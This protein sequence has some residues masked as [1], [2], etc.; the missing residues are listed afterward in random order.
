MRWS[1]I[2][3]LIFFSIVIMAVISCKKA[4]EP[5]I[6]KTETNFLVVDGQIN[7]NANAETKITLSRTKKLSDS[8]TFEPELNAIVSLEQEQGA[9]YNLQ[10]QGN[11]VY[12]TILLN[13]PLNKKYRIKIITS[14]SIAYQSEFVIAKAAPPIDSIT[15]KQEDNVTISVHSRDAINATKYYRWDYVETWSYNSVLPTIWGVKN[16]NAFLKDSTTQTDSCWR[17]LP[18]TKIV[19]YSTVALGKDVVSNYPVAI[20][21]KDDEK[22]SSRYSMLLYQYAITPEAYQYFKLI[23]KNSQQLGTLFDTQPS[24]I[25]GNIVC[26]SNPNI[27][28][29][30][31]VTAG[32]STQKRF[33]LSNKTLNNW[34][35]SNPLGQCGGSFIQTI[36][37]DPGNSLY[38]DYSDTTYAPYYF[39]TGGIVIAKKTCLYCTE[40]GGTNVKPSYW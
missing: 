12:K 15:W 26:I 30:G 29:I 35:Y 31:F 10:A 17:S 25:E 3:C 27:P 11:G 18:S 20:I 39:I 6:I 2:A 34:N 28:V 9:I 19:L 23:E 1:S 38:Y 13:L 14:N 8:V 24:Q 32:T 21:P 40:H 36:P 7:C 22:I 16:K 33:F 37:Q 5:E 4:Y